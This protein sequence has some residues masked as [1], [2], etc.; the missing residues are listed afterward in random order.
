LL[1][2]FIPSLQ[3]KTWITMQNEKNMVERIPILAD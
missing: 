3:N 1:V 2:S